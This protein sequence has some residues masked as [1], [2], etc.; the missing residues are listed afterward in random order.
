M[1]D[2]YATDERIMQLFEEY[3]P[4]WKELFIGSLKGGLNNGKTIKKKR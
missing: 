4:E 2:N 3:T 1:N